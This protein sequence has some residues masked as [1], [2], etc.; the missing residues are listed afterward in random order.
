MSAE[1]DKLEHLRCILK[2]MGSVAVAYSGGVDSS[3]LLRVARDVLGDRAIA[4]LNVSGGLSEHE[5]ESAV[6]QARELGVEPVIVRS[7]E[8]EDPEFLKNRPDR[9]YRCKKAVFS[10]I[11]RAARERGIEH[12][13]DGGNVDDLSEDRPGR[14]AVEELGVRSPL[15]EAGLY[16]SEVRELS[17]QLGLPT[18]DKPS[19][20]CLVT[21]I[22][23]YERITPE[24]LRMIEQAETYI[25]SLGVSQLRV[26]HHGDIARIEALPE[27]FAVI[28]QSREDIVRELKHIGFVYIDLDIQGFRSGSMSEALR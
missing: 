16:K 4:V 9:C 26:R 20:A 21:R 12:V 13:T 15:A 14:R 27:D 1:H 25:R 7:R 28:L 8:A 19:N 18:A 24:K 22:P 10:E 17:K 2:G 11:I 5:R 23:F 3:L 6:R